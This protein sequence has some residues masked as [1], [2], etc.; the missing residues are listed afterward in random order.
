MDL[1]MK[2]EFAA[3]AWQRFL[4]AH[5]NCHRLPTLADQ[6]NLFGRTQDAAIAADSEPGDVTQG[7]NIVN[8]LSDDDG[9]DWIMENAVSVVKEEQ[10]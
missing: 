7:S 4:S 1:S 9:I 5:V 10:V 8:S 6:N 2:N 3:K